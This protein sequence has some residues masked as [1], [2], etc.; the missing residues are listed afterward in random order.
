MAG[1]RHVQ[2]LR[3][4]E[5]INAWSGSARLHWPPLAQ[6][7]RSAGKVRVLDV[8][9]GAG[10]LPIRLWHRARRAGLAIELHGMDRSASAIDYARRR[11]AEQG[12]DVQFFLGD[13]LGERLPDGYDALMC[14][15][16][17]HHL[18]PDKAAELLLRMAGVGRQL[19]L[20]NDLER[21]LTGFL[22]A[23]VGTRLLSRSRVVHVD[24]PRSV[25]AAFSL[26]EVR[27][28]AEQAGLRD[29]RLVRRWPCRFVLIARGAR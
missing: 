16:F 1:E 21:S 20:V 23:W 22:L 7:A 24:G 8:A 18:A 25:R 13:A 6:L 17:L 28:L 27:R 9:T 3:G 5:R 19:V 29:V 14:S 11:A 2:A 15:L 26:A 12:A 10:D 4:L